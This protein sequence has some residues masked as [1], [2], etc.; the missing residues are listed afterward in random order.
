MALTKSR[1]TTAISWRPLQTAKSLIVVS[2]VVVILAI[3][4]VVSDSQYALDV[5]MRAILFATL[6][7]GLNI[8]V[9]QAAVSYTHLTLPTTPYV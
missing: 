3:V 2:I 8:V 1:T 4:P 9:A 5:L 6:A 7:I